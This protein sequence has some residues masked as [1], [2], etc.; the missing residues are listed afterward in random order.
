M[1]ARTCCARGRQDQRR[2]AQVVLRVEAVWR[3][4]AGG[5]RPRVGA[6]VLDGEHERGALGVRLLELDQPREARLP[7]TGRASSSTSSRTSSRLPTTAA[8]CHTEAWNWPANP[9][10]DPSEFGLY[11][12]ERGCVISTLA[13]R[14]LLESSLQRLLR[15]QRRRRCAE[16]MT[17][18]QGLLLK[19]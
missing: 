5:A 1:C 10:P 13:S 15:T 12:V 16:Y 18:G 6:L 8:V 11:T 19:T 7:A 9:Q 3:S 4:A 14:F 2:E 17:V